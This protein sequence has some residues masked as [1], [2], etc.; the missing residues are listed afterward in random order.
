MFRV[1][2][3]GVQELL[4]LVEMFPGSTTDNLSKACVRGR[5]AHSVG[6]QLGRAREAGL[7]RNEYIS[8]PRR[9]C[10]WYRV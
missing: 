7:V 4:D 10:I 2:R 1:A 6:I 5:T 8:C 9:T 3:N